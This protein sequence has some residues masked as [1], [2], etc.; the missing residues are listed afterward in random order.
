MVFAQLLNDGGWQALVVPTQ[1][2]HSKKL[3]INLS[4][5]TLDEVYKAGLMM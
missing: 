5:E 1:R 3:V 2:P 4:A